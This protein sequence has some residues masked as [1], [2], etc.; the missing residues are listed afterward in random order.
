MLAKDNKKQHLGNKK[1][2]SSQKNLVKKNLVNVGGTKK[3]LVKKKKTICQPPQAKIF[4]ENTVTEPS[5]PNE[6]KPKLSLR[7]EKR[8][9]DEF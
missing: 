7:I 4:P 3:N 9:L 1:Q 2:Q 8:S 5:F 6:K